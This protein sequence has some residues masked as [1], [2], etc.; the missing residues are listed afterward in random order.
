MTRKNYVV[1]IFIFRLIISTIIVF[2]KLIIDIFVTF[3]L[4]ENNNVLQNLYFI[5]Y[6][7]DH[8]VIDSFNNLSKNVHVNE[9]ELKKFND[10]NSK[11]I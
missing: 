6:K 9:I 5:Y 8:F 4:N 7:I 2:L 10:E 11:N 3:M 1:L